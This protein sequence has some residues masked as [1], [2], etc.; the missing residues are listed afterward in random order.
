VPPFRTPVDKEKMLAIKGANGNNLKS[1]DAF[2]PV[3]LMTCVTG[4]SGSGKSTLVNDTLYLTAAKVLNRA[5]TKPAG[6]EAID[7]LEFFDKVVDIDQSAI[8]R[9][10]R[11]NPAT[12]TGLFG[13]IRELFAATAESRAR[14]YKPGRFSFNVKGGTSIT[15]LPARYCPVR[16]AAHLAMVSGDP[17]A[18]ICPPCTPAPG[19][20]STT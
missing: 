20:I 2:I 17:S 16:E 5:S 13:P 4:V 6:C 19:P 1:V 3:G 14:G 15:R 9:T 11:S 10:P 7:G 8:G 12:Y 18:T